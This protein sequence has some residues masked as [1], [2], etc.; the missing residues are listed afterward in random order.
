VITTRGELSARAVIVT[1]P[2]DLIA[3]GAVTFTPEIA[4]KREAASALPL[5]L[6]NKVVLAVDKPDAFPAERHLFGDPSRA[7]TGGYHLRPFGRPLIEG[8]FGGRHARELEAEG[9]GAATEFAIEE[10]AALLGSDLRRQLHGISETRWAADPWSGGAYSH[11][12]PGGAWARAALAQPIDNRLFFAGEGCSPHS[13]ST[14]H[15]AAQSGVAAAES[16][17]A[18][19]RSR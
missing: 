16:V 6:A 1:L 4:S 12:R 19:M 9:E 18:A 5:G 15:G 2:T 7:E 3:A 11:A 14:A 8:F 13:F 17:L 10:L